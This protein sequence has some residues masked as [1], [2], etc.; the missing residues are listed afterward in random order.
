M[1]FA[2]EAVPELVRV[3][4]YCGRTSIALVS[5]LLVAPAL[6][7]CF[8]NINA[9]LFWKS[10]G[11]PRPPTLR[12]TTVGSGWRPLGDHR[13]AG[14]SG[15]RPERNLRPR[16]NATLLR[17]HNDGHWQELPNPWI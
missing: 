16:I 12:P 5:S 14:G 13:D 8:T 2:L 11:P 3:R 10:P 1:R 9:I 6:A 4:D 15:C 17:K 7:L